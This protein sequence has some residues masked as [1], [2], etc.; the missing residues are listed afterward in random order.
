MLLKFHKWSNMVFVIL[1]VSQKSFPKARVSM[2]LRLYYTRFERCLPLVRQELVVLLE[3]RVSR[4]R[5]CAYYARFLSRSA[6]WNTSV[7]PFDDRL[8]SDY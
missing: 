6:A 7:T 3:T 1:I 2:R 4:V 8:R 5:R